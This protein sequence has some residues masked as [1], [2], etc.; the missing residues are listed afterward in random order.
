MNKLFKTAVVALMNTNSNFK[1]QLISSLQH[2]HRREAALSDS[3]KYLAGH[4][5]VLFQNRGGINARGEF[6]LAALGPYG[7]EFAA[8][9]NT[10]SPRCGE[11]PGAILD[12]TSSWCYLNHFD[13]ERLVLQVYELVKDKPD[14]PLVFPRA[15]TF[16]RGALAA[17]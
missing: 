11:A 3:L 16:A 4:F 6:N 8:M 13:A 12:A 10:S 9:L 17:C 7:V 1:D 2:A 14:T 5:G 15:E